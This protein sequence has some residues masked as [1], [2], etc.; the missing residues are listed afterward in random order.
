[1]TLKIPRFG[2]HSL[3][4]FPE[5]LSSD[6]YVLNNPLTSARFEPS[7]PW[8]SKPACYSKYTKAISAIRTIKKLIIMSE[9]ENGFRDFSK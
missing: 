8:V 1:M 5:H 6:F 3:K 9:V 4:S 7:S 2:I